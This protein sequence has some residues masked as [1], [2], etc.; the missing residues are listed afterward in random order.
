M[1]YTILL[2]CIFFTIF[3]VLLSSTTCTKHLQEG[4]NREK[5][6]GFG[7][8]AVARRS[9]NSR[10]Q[11]DFQCMNIYQCKCHGA[12]LYCWTVILILGNWS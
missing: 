3:T 9:P 6:K 11:P 2:L 1:T 8:I 7:G 12:S 4:Q 5:K 10:D